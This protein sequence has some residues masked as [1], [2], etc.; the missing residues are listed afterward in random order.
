MSEAEAASKESD[1]TADEVEEKLP[2]IKKRYRL[3]VLVLR[4][5]AD[6][7]FDLHGELNP[8]KDDRLPPFSIKIEGEAGA[9]KDLVKK[10][11]RKDRITPDHEPQ[12]AL[13]S[14][15]SDLTTYRFAG[16]RKPFQGTPVEKYSHG[17]GVCLNMFVERHY[18]TR[19]YGASPKAAIDKIRT[20]L[21]NDLPPNSPVEKV[22]N[23][24]KDLVNEE[25]AADQ[26]RVKE[27]YA[28][29]KVPQGTKNRVEEGSK[30]VKSLNRDWWL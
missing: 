5:L 4:P 30:K 8:K 9:Y 24:V 28:S 23:K 2:G 17:E 6:G 14:Y 27:I 18:K 29:A 10:G 3:N 21:N 7:D 19:T 16:F 13:M 15:V 22:Q 20:S 26:K 12:H 25:L 1:A 11:K